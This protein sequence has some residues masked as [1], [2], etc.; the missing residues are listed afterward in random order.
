[1]D[2]IINQTER[3]IARW[4]IGLVVAFILLIVLIWAGARFYN[5]WQEKTVLQRAAQ[6]LDQ[7]DLRAAS[8]SAKRAHQINPGSAAAARMMASVAERAADRSALDWRLKAVELAPD[9]PD[10]QIALAATALQFEEWA[11]AARALNAVPAEKHNAPYHV[12]AA[13]LAR[14]QGRLEEARGH[15]QK[16]VELEPEN[17]SHR[18]QQ[19]ILQL[20]VDDPAIQSEARETLRQLRD[21]PAHRVEAIRAL[22]VDGAKN[23]GDA[24]ELLELG[25]ALK[26]DPQAQFVDAVVY[27]DMLQKL[28]HPD[29]VSFLSELEGRAATSPD[30]LAQLLTW[31]NKNNLS[32]LALSYV[33]RLPGE[34]V[35]TWPVPLAVAESHAAMNEWEALERWLEAHPWEGLEMLRHAYLARA[36][37]AQEKTVAADREWA[38]AKKEAS[39]RAAHLSL[40]VRTALEWRWISEAEELLWQLAKD[41]AE[42][43]EALSSLYRYYSEKGDTAGLYRTLNRL[44]ELLPEDKALQNNLAQVAMLLGVDTERA[45]RIAMELSQKEPKNAAFVSTYAFSQFSAGNAAAAVRTM[46]S[47]P[48]E[49][50]REPAQA[51]YYG[52]FLASAGDA[53]KASEYLALAEEAKLL[54]EEQALVRKAAGKLN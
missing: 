32:A 4:V 14:A 12:A 44:V 18:L 31:M 30:D 40:L 20:N 36:L 17:K 52:I 42:G 39:T 35:K 23:R 45:R 46:E 28:K 11:T 27:L 51:A 25:R 8:V 10:D 53:K 47:L 2:S 22:I 9:S 6:H 26:D 34:V 24:A 41:P 16:A 38:A 7:G 5:R 15:W 49:T 43:P 50:M 19:A 3:S 54:P 33:K 48:A 13:K 37:R 29:F 21:D 1:M